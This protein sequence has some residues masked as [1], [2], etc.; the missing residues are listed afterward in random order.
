[1]NIRKS[2]GWYVILALCALPLAPC[3]SSDGIEKY[4]YGPPQVSF[5]V[6]EGSHSSFIEWW[7]G[8]FTLESQ[9]GHRYGAMV[10]YFQP[11]LRIISI[12]DIDDAIFYHDVSFF[13]ADYDYAEGGLDLHWGDTDRWW[14]TDPNNPD[15]RLDSVGDEIELHFDIV[16]GKPPFLVGGDG[17]IGWTDNGSYYYSLTR[18]QVDGELEIKGVTVP[19]TGIGW[20]DHQY[21]DFRVSRGWDWFSV[22]LDNNAEL[23]FWQIVNR[24]ETSDSRDLTVD[25]PDETVFHTQDFT[26]EKLETWTSPHSGRTYGTRWRMVEPENDIDLTIEALFNDQEIISGITVIPIT[27]FWEGNTTVSGTFR[28]LPVTG[29]GYA[30]LPR[31]WPAENPNPTTT[32][33]ENPNPATTSVCPPLQYSDVEYPWGNRFCDST[34]CQEK[35]DP[36]VAKCEYQG[37]TDAVITGKIIG[38]S[39]IHSDILIVAFGE[40]LDQQVRSSTT[41]CIPEQREFEIPAKSGDVGDVFVI[42]YKSYFGHECPE[43]M[44]CLDTRATGQYSN[45]PITVH[46]GFNEGINI[47]IIYFDN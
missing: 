34:N 21:G 45:N 5:P 24:D 30:E 11:P 38:G 13:D 20:M 8:N 6:D 42:D 28:G 4:P 10:A 14:R 25:F 2:A 36:A 40:S 44:I 31:P 37:E 46:P 41:I 33:T 9:D 16:S 1:M 12:S 26:L 27:T 15:Y 32:E 3:C 19:V 7:Y 47:E 35:C 43:G 18:L 29:V 39:S 17:L 23:I 22:Q